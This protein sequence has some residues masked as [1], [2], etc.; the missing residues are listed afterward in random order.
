LLCVAVHLFRILW[1]KESITKK[2]IIFKNGNKNYQ[3]EGIKIV[4]ICRWI[5]YKDI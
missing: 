2:R 1:E 5:L 3:Y 4:D